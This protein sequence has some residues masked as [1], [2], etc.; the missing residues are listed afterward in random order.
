[1]GEFWRGRPVNSQNAGNQLLPAENAAKTVPQA[2]A[3]NG[4]DYGGWHKVALQQVIQIHAM[5]DALLQIL[6]RLIQTIAL[7]FRLLL[8]KLD[9]KCSLI[10]SD[11]RKCG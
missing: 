9:G 5:A 8:Q 2:E 11:P 4:C 1:M 10:Q 7:G 6:Y 3:G